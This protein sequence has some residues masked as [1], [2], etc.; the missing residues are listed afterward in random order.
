MGEPGRIDAMVAM[1]KCSGVFLAVVALCLVCN[2]ALAEGAGET[3][4]WSAPQNPGDRHA[5]FRLWIPSGLVQVR[6]VVSLMPGYA[7]D[8]RGMAADPEFQALAQRTGTVL[9]GCSIKGDEY[10]KAKDWSGAVLLQALGELSQLSNRPEIAQAPLLMWGHSAGG[11][12]NYNFVCWKPERVAAFI[13]NKGGYYDGTARGA[14]LGVPGLWFAGQKDEEYRLQGIT[15]YF[16][17]G[18]R[19]GAPWTLAFEPNSGHELGR[20]KQM[21]IFYFETLLGLRLEPSAPAR[22][23]P[24]AARAWIGGLGGHEIRPFDPQR[25]TRRITAWLPDEITAKWWQAFVT[26]T[27][28]PLST[29]SVTPP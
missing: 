1:P 18:R 24:V 9:L 3:Y 7:G 26:G 19:Q 14:A 22:L 27:P 5:E 16:T 4:E 23:K 6:A 25:D 12:F 20:T 15:D 11:M 29:A 8:G 13:V 2:L 10:P 28:F 17:V 21:G